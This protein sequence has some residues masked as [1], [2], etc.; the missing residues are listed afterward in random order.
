MVLVR[1]FEVEF[2]LVSLRDTARVHLQFSLLARSRLLLSLQVH[3][4]V[5][6]VSIEIRLDIAA[7]KKKRLFTSMINKP[8]CERSIETV[9]C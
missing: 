8:F 4:T 5:I 2:R 7:L 3:E 9:L 1:C 6:S